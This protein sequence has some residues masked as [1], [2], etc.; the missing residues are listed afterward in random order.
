MPEI[1]SRF[2]RPVRMECDGNARLRIAGQRIDLETR[3]GVNVR[4]GR[5]LAAR[6]QGAI[7]RYLRA[8]PEKGA[9][10]LAAP[11]GDEKPCH[12]FL[13]PVSQRENAPDAAVLFL[14]AP[15]HDGAILELALFHRLAF[16]KG[17]GGNRVFSDRGRFDGELRA[18]GGIIVNIRREVDHG[19]RIVHGDRVQ[20]LRLRYEK[21]SQRQR[22][23]GGRAFH[24]RHHLAPSPHPFDSSP[25]LVFSGG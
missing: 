1:N 24:A 7:E 15:Q 22:K 9:K 4:G 8:R 3:P 23:R 20:R 11:V 12:R 6:G 25:R 17:F 18:R 14:A 16:R 10:P 5:I 2:R 13:P 21:Q 19:M